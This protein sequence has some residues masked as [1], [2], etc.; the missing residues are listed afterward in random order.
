MNVYL[1]IFISVISFSLGNY[2]GCVSLYEKIFDHAKWMDNLALQIVA[3]DHY[4]INKV[5]HWGTP[6]LPDYKYYGFN[7]FGFKLGYT[8]TLVKPINKFDKEI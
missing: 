1:I 6:L 2:F 5:F 8:K 7:L 4:M 3:V